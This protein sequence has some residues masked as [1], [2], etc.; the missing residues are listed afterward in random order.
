MAI[1]YGFFISHHHKETFI[2][3]A[4]N[5]LALRKKTID[6]GFAEN[7]AM[8]N[9]SCWLYPSMAYIKDAPGG[10]SKWKHYIIQSGC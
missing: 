10:I 9:G 4:T 1:I 8:R 6:R 7:D 3:R 2:Q 5:H